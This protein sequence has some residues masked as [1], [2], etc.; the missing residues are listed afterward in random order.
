MA[1]S[2]SPGSFICKGCGRRVEGVQYTLDGKA[3]CYDCFQKRDA[4][5]RRAEAEKKELYDY[6]ARLFDIKELP[7]SAIDRLDR[8]IKDG[9]K[10]KAMKATLYY[11]Y[12]IMGNS[13]K[14]P[15][16]AFYA[17]KDDYDRARKY[18]EEM[19]ELKKKNDEVKLTSR[20]ITVKIDPDS[21]PPSSR[22][23]EKKLVKIE[24]L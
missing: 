8:L 5:K 1:S 24:D 12:A 23:R 11:H 4:E 20:Q 15:D 17:I 16:E 14:D 21:L 13:P 7:Q 3:L 9:K 22:K 2:A 18:V 19:R 6:V 10:P